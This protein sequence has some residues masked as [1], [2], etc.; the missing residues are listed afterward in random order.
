MAAVK[1][2]APIDA[3]INAV[4]AG[5][6]TAFFP[7]Q[8]RRPLGSSLPGRAAIKYWRSI[9]PTGASGSSPTAAATNNGQTISRRLKQQPPHRERPTIYLGVGI[10]KKCAD[11]D[12]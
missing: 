10:K 9:D 1:I 6:E 8:F 11:D 7:L 12:S 3:F 2:P 5:D 4:N